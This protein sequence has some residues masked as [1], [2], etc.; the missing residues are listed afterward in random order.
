MDQLHNSV[1]DKND[2]SRI[3]ELCLSQARAVPHP[4]LDFVQDL[5]S[6]L[7][8]NE[9]WIKIPEGKPSAGSVLCSGDGIFIIHF[10]NR[11]SALTV[12][13]QGCGEG[14]EIPN[15]GWELLDRSFPDFICSG[16][17]PKFTP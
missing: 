4:E 9:Q 17:C 10:I 12:L 7:S 6:F 8:K 13:T 3:G 1:V 2:I 5:F 16:K 11:E 14:E 15:P